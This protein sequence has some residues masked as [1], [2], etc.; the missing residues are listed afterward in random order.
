M[1]I[2]T[3]SASYLLGEKIAQLLNEKY[4]P[5][6]IE[7][8]PD[9]EIYVRIE[10]E[11]EKEVA[12]IQT[13]YPNDKLIELFL[14]QDALRE[15]GV[16][17]IITVVPYFGYSRQDK[18]FKEGEAISAR[19]MAKHIELYSDIFIGIDLHAPSILNWFSIPT[20]HLHAT[21]PIARFLKER[22]VDVVISPDKGGVERA[23]LVAEAMNAEFDYLEKVRLSGEEVVIKPKNLDVR[24][25]IVGIVDDIISTGGTIARAA[26]QLRRQGARKIYAV[27]T[28]GLFIGKA[29]EN[30]KKVNDF[31]STDTIESKYSKIT[32]AEV[33][34]RALQEY[35]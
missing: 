3:G 15:K 4:I 20:V 34:A 24:E 28:H 11:I 10:G 6:V 31:A 17:R 25:K 18:I 27:C 30:M 5:P 2:V 7:K 13:T 21:E 33:I 29:E 12:L 19:A 32:V 35:A 1:N 8:F 16:E 26:E 22:D 23:K 14:L 9:G